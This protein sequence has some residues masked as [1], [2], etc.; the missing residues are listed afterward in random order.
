MEEQAVTIEREKYELPNPFIVMATQ[1][2]R[3]QIGTFPLPESQLDR[4][5]MKIRVGFPSKEK[6]L[7]IL[8][9]PVKNEEI[10][11]V[12]KV[13]DKDKLLD[14]RKKVKEVTVS[15]PILE[16]AHSLLDHTRSN[17]HY[18]SL[19]PR[20]GQ[21]LIQA[22]RAWAFIHAKG[23]VT[24][25]DVQKVFPLVCSHRLSSSTQD[26]VSEYSLSEKIIQSVDIK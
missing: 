9:S 26:L 1:N 25:E 14:L 8:K 19:S 4:F 22:S 16:F 11:T 13:L 18:N 10:S 12:R 15:E 20:A 17:S 24:P 3:Y 7:E 5:M 2:P 6:E 21:D 23:F